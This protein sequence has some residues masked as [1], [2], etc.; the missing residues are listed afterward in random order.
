MNFITGPSRTFFSKVK[1]TMAA[2]AMTAPGDRVLIGLSG[3]PDSVALARVLLGLRDEL[4]ITVGAAHLNHCLR[5]DASIQ[6]EGFVRAFAR[7]HN[8]DIAVETKEIKPF[9]KTQGLSL[10]T[11][12][13]SARYAFFK[14]IADEGGYTRIATGHNWDDHVEQILMNLIRGAGPKGLRGIAPVREN[15]FIRPL[16]RVPKTLILDVL[17]DLEQ[18]FVLD[19][20]NSDPAFFRNRVRTQLIPLL[21]AEY[22]PEIKAGLDR[23]STILIQEDDF[24]ETEAQKRFNAILLESGKVQVVLSVP[25]LLALH[26]AL[27]A[28]VLRHGLMHVKQNL[29]RITHTHIKDILTLCDGEP[30][31]SLD[32]PCQIRVYKQRGQLVIQKEEQPLRELGARQ[33]SKRRKT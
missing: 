27:A 8:I 30:G 20:S 4:N 7:A 31:K 22:N 24:L 21:A 18:P 3:G 15:R 12:G 5:G 13:R 29:R 25:K 32:L 26:P 14:R 28:R 1:H 33:K 2:Y 16:I 23:L 17:S 6:D 10:E 11:A 9:A 19:E